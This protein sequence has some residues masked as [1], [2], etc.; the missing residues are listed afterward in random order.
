[1]NKSS[2]GSDNSVQEQIFFES[3][4]KEAEEGGDREMIMVGLCYAN[5]HGVQKSKG[6]SDQWLVINGDATL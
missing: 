2:T 4:L 3:A 6:L 5:G 1:M